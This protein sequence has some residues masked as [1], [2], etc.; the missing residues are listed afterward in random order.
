METATGILPRMR[1]PKPSTYRSCAVLW[2]SASMMC[3]PARAA[4]PSGTFINTTYY[5]LTG[6]VVPYRITAGPDGAMWFTIFKGDQI[7]RITTAGVVTQY[8]VPTPYSQPEGIVAGP[9]GA[10]WFAESANLKI[11]RITTAGAITEYQ[12]PSS[13]QPAEIAAGPDGALWFTEAIGNQVGRITVSGA[14]TEYPVPTPNSSPGGIAVGPDSAL[15]FTE[16]SANQIGRI[17]TA[18][19]I[20][21]YP[22]DVSK[23]S[24]PESIAAGPD[25][26]LW[27]TQRAG[28]SI[29][30][31]TTAGAVTDYPAYS[32][33]PEWITAGSD[34]ALWFTAT[35]TV[36]RITTSGVVTSY[37]IHRGPYVK[38]IAAGPDGALWFT[39]SPSASI[40]R[41]PACGL[42]FSATFAN[43]ALTMNFDLGVDEPA[44][45][46]ILLRTSTGTDV[47]F[48]LA[49]PAVVPPNTFTM[50][51][52]AVPNLGEVV[53]Q[54]ALSAGPG[55]SLCS[56]WTTVNT[57]Q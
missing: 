37:A 40:G 27:F 11:G 30:R 6:D 20:T 21:E 7:G 54:P 15:W 51:W 48:S 16:L 4:T 50:N 14:V 47:P 31:I 12:L 19:V 9:D 52:S 17:T 57:A 23:G 32:A 42:G 13:G 33:Y 38:G 44:T 18:G 53:V 28:E 10:L 39:R 24:E 26:A 22:I 41:M 56:E 1:V 3:L 5:P 45:F 46:D 35:G 2:L 25:G 29:G 43:G 55:Q 8:P 36:A 49:I 34:G